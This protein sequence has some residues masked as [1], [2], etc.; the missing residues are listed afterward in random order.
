MRTKNESF[1]GSQ[2]QRADEAHGGDPK[3]FKSISQAPDAPPNA[4][5]VHSLPSP[6]VISTTLRYI[7]QLFFQQHFYSALLRNSFPIST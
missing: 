1:S 4:S 7:V 3:N 2:M 6:R 5:I